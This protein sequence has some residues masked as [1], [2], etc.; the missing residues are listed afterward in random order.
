MRRVIERFEQ[1]AMA[2]R[3]LGRRVRDGLAI[4]AVLLFVPI[5]GLTALAA[6]KPFWH[7]I[8]SPGSSAPSAYT[9]APNFTSARAGVPAAPR[10]LSEL[11][12][13]PTPEML[14]EY[15]PLPP[16]WQTPVRSFED[17]YPELTAALALIEAQSRVHV[18]PLA[19][20]PA[21]DS[22]VAES[23]PAGTAPEVAPSTRSPERPAE[24][25]ATASAPA[26]PKPSD[27][28]PEAASHQTADA[29]GARGEADKGNGNASGNGNGSGGANDSPAPTENAG[30]NGNGGGN[31][32]ASG[33]GDGGSNDDQGGNDHGNAGGD[34]EGN[35][36]EDGNVDGNENGDANE[37][38]SD[39]AANIEAGNAEAGNAETNDGGA[40]TP[41]SDEE[42]NG[43][44]NADGNGD[45]GNSGNDNGADEGEGKHACDG[46]NAADEGD[47]ENDGANADGQDNG[48]G[49][50]PDDKQNQDGGNNPGS[51]PPGQDKKAGRRHGFTKR[52]RL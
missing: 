2:P 10:R 51:T 26:E 40:E 46:A 50:D 28:A 34:G 32:N 43:N 1:W 39:N 11:F 36:D 45:G 21:V 52:K 4:A 16:L 27:S 18:E 42:S 19:P 5:V 17:T 22:Y 14:G 12:R 3:S 35:G 38:C 6:D 29:T 37:N 30:G 33:D 8:W 23:P 25:M 9:S 15:A 49:N 47:S 31:G 24:D 41:A 7:T 48:S 44:G 13:T 20:L